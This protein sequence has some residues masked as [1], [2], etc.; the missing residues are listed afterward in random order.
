MNA[1]KDIYNSIRDRNEREIMKIEHFNAHM[2]TV[3]RKQMSAILSKQA[4][5]ARVARARPPFFMQIKQS[6][7]NKETLFPAVCFVTQCYVY[8]HD[9]RPMFVCPF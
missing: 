2:S 8:G 6:V 9:R 4:L 1:M 3:Q 7:N 5:R